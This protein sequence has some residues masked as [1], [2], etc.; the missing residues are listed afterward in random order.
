MGKKYTIEAY[1]GLGDVVRLS[2]SE[3]ELRRMQVDA[4]WEM[5]RAS[6]EIEEGRVDI[7]YAEEMK[8]K[9]KWMKEK[10]PL[11]PRKS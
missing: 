6:M 5:A 11:I 7:P 2:L 4:L 8:I 10:F 9:E 3:E 1:D